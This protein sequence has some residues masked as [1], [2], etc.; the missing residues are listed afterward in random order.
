[1]LLKVYHISRYTFFIF[2][3][4]VYTFTGKKMSQIL[5]KTLTGQETGI[6][7]LFCNVICK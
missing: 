4:A 2:L 7:S 5:I 1:M 6:F 3:L